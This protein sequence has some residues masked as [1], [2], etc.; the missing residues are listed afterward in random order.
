MVQLEKL[1]KLDLIEVIS[2]HPEWMDWKTWLKRQNVSDVTLN[3]SAAFNTYPLMIQAAVNGFGVALGWGHLVDDLLKSGEL[4]R[5][6]GLIGSRTDAG[7]YLLRPKSKKTFPECLIV[8]DWLLKAS[9][10]RKRYNRS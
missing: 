9:A 6:L 10:A 3:Q 5:P 8:E 7:Y 1:I 4:V 2:R